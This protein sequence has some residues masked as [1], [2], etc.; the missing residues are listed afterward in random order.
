MEVFEIR[1]G[2]DFIRV[3]ITKNGSVYADLPIR[4]GDRGSEFREDIVLDDRGWRFS[5]TQIDCC[6]YYYFNMWLKHDGRIAWVNDMSY[7]ISETEEPFNPNYPNAGV[8]NKTAMKLYNIVEK[9]KA[10]QKRNLPTNEIFELRKYYLETTLKVLGYDSIESIEEKLDDSRGYLG[11]TKVAK[12]LGNYR[13]LS[14]LVHSEGKEGDEDILICRAKEEAT[15]EDVVEYAKP[16]KLIIDE[17]VNFMQRIES[18]LTDKRDIDPEY[19]MNMK[20]KVGNNA[21]KEYEDEVK[22][23]AILLLELNTDLLTDEQRKKFNIPKFEILDELSIKDKISKIIDD[24][25]FSDACRIEDG[26]AYRQAQMLT[27]LVNKK[28]SSNLID[29]KKQIDQKLVDILQSELVEIKERG[30]AITKYDEIHEK[31]YSK[32]SEIY[33]SEYIL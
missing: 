17:N 3:K 8:L 22:K 13:D 11:L 15:R 31:Y 1:N 4:F 26:F 25:Q 12:L 19:R 5:S 23:V 14:A 30:V 33:E 2:W 7:R 10:Y 32:E 18:G 28:I 21:W 16:I 6:D 20:E 27:T 9:I 24:P 29:G